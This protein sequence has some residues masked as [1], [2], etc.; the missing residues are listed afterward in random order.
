MTWQV[1]VLMGKVGELVD[2]YHA[3]LALL[4]SPSPVSLTAFSYFFT[5]GWV[6][7][8]AA[9][10]AIIEL[11]DSAQFEAFGLGM[12]L[13]YTAFLSTFV[14]G[15]YEAGNV[16]EHP[17]KNVMSLLSTEDMAA[18]LSDDLASLVDDETVPVFIPK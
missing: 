14:F 1:G 8:S 18:S 2:A 17:L 4:L 6:Y 12:T 5:A 15:L 10:I 16:V 7:F 11:G 3:S 13:V 9:A